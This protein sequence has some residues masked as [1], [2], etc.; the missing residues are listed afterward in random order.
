ML[1]VRRLLRCHPWG[2]S[3]YDPVPPHV[4]SL[5]AW[6]NSKISFSR[7]SCRCAILFGFQYFMAPKTQAPAPHQQTSQQTG[8]PQAPAGSPP[9]TPGVAAPNPGGT[10]PATIAPAATRESVLAKT[11]RVR[12]ET[13]RLKGSIDLVG[14]RIDDLTLLNYREEPEPRVPQIVLLAPDGTAD[15]YFAE[16]GWVAGD[17][18]VKVPGRDTQW[19]SSGGT[20]TPD[21]PVELTWD[22]GEGLRF[23]RGITRSTAITCSR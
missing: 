23:T 2:G 20:L 21:H 11:P 16:F 6:T 13:P 22:N 7:S 3:G 10:T 14:A 12:I 19:T 5:I 8:A 18:K 17:A 1:A 4:G 15:P 9:A